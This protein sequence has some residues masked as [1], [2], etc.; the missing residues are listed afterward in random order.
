LAFSRQQ[1]LAP[2]ILNLAE[3]ITNTEKMLRRLIGEDVELRSENVA[4]GRVKID[5]GQIEQVVMNLAVN[6]RDAMPNGGTLTISTFDVEVDEDFARTHFDMSAGRYVLL[7]VN[8]TGAGMDSATLSR[9]FEPFFTTKGSGKGTGLG[10]STVFGIVRQSG[11]NIWVDSEPGR[12][13]TFSIYLPVT[14]ERERSSV[15]APATM[16]D[17]RGTETIL[18]VEDE[19]QVR[20]L[21]V[22]I[23]ERSGYNVLEAKT[24][25]DALAIARAHPA[26]I[27]ALLTDMVMPQ[28]NGRQLYETLQGIRQD[29]C[30]LYMSGYTD[31]AVLHAAS[32]SGE[33]CFLQKP[34]SPAT[35][36]RAIREVLDA[37]GLNGPPAK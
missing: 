29:V 11:G 12:G 37:C 14:R 8:D 27:H 24:P 25:E 34:F 13:T 9:I 36:T 4:R 20:K 7:R 17:N 6:A 30:V 10:L 2:R 22:A 3:V 15:Q 1:V 5:P 32:L 21:A 33:S 35:L 16:A 28:M 26:R 18:V 23:L 31:D 19:T